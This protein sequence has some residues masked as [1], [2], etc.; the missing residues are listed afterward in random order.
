MTKM[1]WQYV[2]TENWNNLAQLINMD[3][4]V[5]CTAIQGTLSIVTLH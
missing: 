1:N 3:A 2:I 5:V 4:A